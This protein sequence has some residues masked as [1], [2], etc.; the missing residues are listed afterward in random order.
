MHNNAINA[1]K[2]KA[3]AGEADASPTAGDSISDSEGGTNT[4]QICDA[5]DHACYGVQTSEGL[6]IL[7]KV[8]LMWH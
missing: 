8:A 4:P 3:G 7:K 5:H 1:D 6:H 2:A